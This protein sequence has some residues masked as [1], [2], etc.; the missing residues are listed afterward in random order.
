M[1]WLALHAPRGALGREVWN[2]EFVLLIFQNSILRFCNEIGT[3]IVF[4]ETNSVGQV[5]IQTISPMLCKHQMLSINHKLIAVGGWDGLKRRNAVWVFDTRTCQWTLMKEKMG[6]DPE[7]SPAGLSGH[8]FTQIDPQTFVI[9]G[10]E[11]S[12][13]YQKRFASVFQLQIDTGRFKN[14]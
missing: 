14:F 2:V 3:R 1:R 13:R 6:T 10:R 5:P 11:G 4:I 8:T 9:T 7:Q 12:V